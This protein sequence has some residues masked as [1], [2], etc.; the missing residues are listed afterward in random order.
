MP[1]IVLTDSRREHRHHARGLVNALTDVNAYL[2]TRSLTNLGTIISPQTHPVSREHIFVPPFL[3]LIAESFS[4]RL[5]Q[6]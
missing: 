6:L 3:R 5:A 2:L 4:E 1:R